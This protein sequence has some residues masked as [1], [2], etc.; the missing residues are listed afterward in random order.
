MTFSSP[1]ALEDQSTSG[2]EHV[3]GA[4]RPAHVHLAPL[5][6]KLDSGRG[7]GQ[8]GT[9]GTAAAGLAA[10]QITRAVTCR[11]GRMPPRHAPPRRLR[12]LDGTPR[13]RPFGCAPVHRRPS[14]CWTSATTHA[15]RPAGATNSTINGPH[16]R[17][18]RRRR[19]A[20][21][22]LSLPTEQGVGL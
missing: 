10:V 14:H 20:T 17:R 21:L 18:R 16:R 6:S 3:A 8:P 19:P 12:P 4:C 9:A 22:S 11:R 7:R 2:E 13:L 15:P 1:L 5:C